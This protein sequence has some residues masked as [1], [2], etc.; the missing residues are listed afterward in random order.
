M[1]ANEA[2]TNVTTLI[3]DLESNYGMCNKRYAIDDIYDKVGIFDW[4]NN[5]IGLTQLKQM[6]SF[7][8]T[9]IK[10]GYTGYVCFKVGAPGCAHGMWAHRN[11]STD[12]YS[13]R[14]GGCLFHSFRFGDNYWSVQ[15]NNDEWISDNNHPNRHEYPLYAVKCELK[16][17]GE[18]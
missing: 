6:Q 12:G 2:L 13:P 18:L 3:N 16:R 8:K 15:F 1:N 9:A 5:F 7:L 17:R 11:E 4:W 10:L 14:E